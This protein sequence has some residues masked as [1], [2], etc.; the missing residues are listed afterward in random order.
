MPP[1]TWWR[2]EPRELLET[3]SPPESKSA[4]EAS[5]NDLL[6]VLCQDRKMTT[7]NRFSADI[8]NHMIR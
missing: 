5:G 4:A 6:T 3:T 7:A 2:G 1:F 8:V